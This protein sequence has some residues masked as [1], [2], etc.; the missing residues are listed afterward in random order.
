MHGFGELAGKFQIRRA[1]FAP[2]Q[3]GVLSVSDGAGDGLIQ[4]LLGLVEAFGGA[5]AGQEGLVVLVV[6][7]GQ[8]VSRFSIGTGDNQGRHA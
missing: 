1:G 5:L 3:V 6:V 4:T 7:G 8:Q 2:H